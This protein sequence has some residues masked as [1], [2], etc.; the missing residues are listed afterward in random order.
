MTS[1]MH[2]FYLVIPIELRAE[3]FD[4]KFKFSL[5]ISEVDEVIPTQKLQTPQM[6]HALF[7]LW[8]MW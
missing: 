7:L 2:S 6:R 3:S 5:N 4:W 1:A 8:V